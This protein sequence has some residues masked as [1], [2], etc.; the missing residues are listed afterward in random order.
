MKIFYLSTHD[1]RSDG[2][3]DVCQHLLAGSRRTN[4]LSPPSKHSTHRKILKQQIL[5]YLVDFKSGVLISEFWPQLVPVIA[6]QSRRTWKSTG[7]EI[8]LNNGPKRSQI[9]K[10]KLHIY[11]AV[12]CSMFAFIRPQDTAIGITLLQARSASTS[13]RVGFE[14][15]RCRARLLPAHQSSRRQHRYIS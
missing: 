14:R 9:E 6:R 12:R 10:S 2:R 4:G 11:Y 13:P 3:A 7:C 5:P 1:S 15:P 8:R